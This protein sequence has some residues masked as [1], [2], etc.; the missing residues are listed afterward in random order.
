MIL[1]YS[2]S[3]QISATIKEVLAK[4]AGKTSKILTLQEAISETSITLTL[5]ASIIPEA[6]TNGLQTLEVLTRGVN[7]RAASGKL[8]SAVEM[9]N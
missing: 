6:L 1:I 3:I 8:T 5:L 9:T 7:N 4:I 2:A